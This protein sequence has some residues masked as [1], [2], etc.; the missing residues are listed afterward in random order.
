MRK[1]FA[2]CSLFLLRTGRRSS[3]QKD[4]ILS[5]LELLSYFKMPFPI[6]SLL[7]YSVLSGR[8]H[9]FFFEIFHA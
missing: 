9:A 2:V 8:L 5:I 1:I 4:F 6:A 3:G 7:I